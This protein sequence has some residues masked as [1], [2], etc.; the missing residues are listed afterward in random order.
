MMNPPRAKP[1]QQIVFKVVHSSLRGVEQT[2]YV[3]ATSM[4]GAVGI[5]EGHPHITAILRIEELGQCLS[6]PAHTGKDAA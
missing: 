4:A 3:V 6:K 1:E 2:A 5:C